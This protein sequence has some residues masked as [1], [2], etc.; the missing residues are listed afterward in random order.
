[1]HRKFQILIVDDDVALA[2][3]LRD[4]LEGEG[5][6]G[7]VATDGQT[8]LTLCRKKEFDLALIDIELPDVPGLELIK[9]LSGLSSGLEYIIITGHASLENAAQAVGQ[10]NILA[11]D[12]KPL[13]VNHLLSLTREVAERKK[14]GKALRETEKRLSAF[15]KAA[16]NA[17][18]LFDSELN[19][20][21]INDAALRFYLPGTKKKEDIIGKNLSDIM[22]NVKE[23]GRYDRY[24]EVIKTGKPFF[25]DDLVRHSKSGDIYLVLRAFKVGNGLGIITTDISERKRA[26]ETLLQS[27]KLKALG[28]M[29]G[30]VAHDFNNL[31]AIILGNAQLLERGVGRYKAEEI[32][33]RL[34]IIAQT[35]YEG[36]ET[37][38][39]LQHFTRREVSKEDY[40]QIDLN[41]IVRSA[42]SSTSPR[43]KDEAEKEGITVKIKEELGHIPLILGNRAQMMEVL[44][45]L[46]FNSVDAMKKGGQITVKTEEKNNK[47][48]LYF[49][50]TGEGIPSHI[51]NKIFDPFFTTKGPKASGLGLSVS[52][53]IIK[54]HGGDIEVESKRGEGSTFT[55]TLPIPSEVPLKKGKTKRQE[56]VPGKKILVIDDEEGIRDVLGRILENEGHRVVL[57]E[58]ARKGLE[59]FKQDNDELTL[60]GMQDKF[61]LVLTDLGMPEMSGWQVAGKIKKIDPDVPVG[62][63]T[64]W[65][66]TT[67][68]EEMEEK[69]VDFILSKPFD[70]TKVVKE[71]NSILKSEK[72]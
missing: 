27:E 67:T 7:T 46:I 57:A 35:A 48:Y 28:E 15:M 5:Y 33:E 45:N 65:A 47:V 58:T 22:P 19:F 18:A 2:S 62:L 56:K 52:Y 8:A 38:R 44:T 34:R 32:K 31:L 41:E 16:P 25:S 30:G 53:G 71:V 13:N 40:A 12:T 68:K 60:A 69:G 70:Y 21:E 66:V 1:M 17:L 63:T 23:T 55:I 39:R 14:L 9:R 6:K 42:V 36:G 29:A 61:N 54:G 59:K 10:R 20:V 64:G 24:L 43:W 4:I 11:Y 3:N 72:R 37:V 50:D 51:K 49:S 26:E